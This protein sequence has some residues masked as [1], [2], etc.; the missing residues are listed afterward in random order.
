[1]VDR[2]EVREVRADEHLALGRLT[3]EAY[4]P[5]GILSPEYSAELLDVGT[6][7]DV[8]TVLV[9][10]DRGQDGELLGGVTYVP[11]GPNPLSEHTEHD[12]ASIRMLAVADHARRRGVGMALT[13]AVLERARADGAEAVVLHSVPTMTAAH[14]LYESVGFGR[15]ASLDWWPEPEV[16]CLGFRLSF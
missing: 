3:L 8:A 14:R 9:A 2:V 1:M 4:R 11:P 15:D 10:V 6:R 16:E 5:H 7:A 12:V 13:Q